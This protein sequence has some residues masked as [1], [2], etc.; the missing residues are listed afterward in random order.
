MNLGFLPKLPRPFLTLSL[1]CTGVGFL[2]QGLAQEPNRPQW[3]WG[4]WAEETNRPAGE[5]CYFRLP[6]EVQGE[7]AEANLHLSADNHFIVWL[8]G[9]R[10]GGGDNWAK[11]QSFDGRS[12]VRQGDNWLAV[13]AW[14]EDAAAGP[15]GMVAIGNLVFQDGRRLFW[16]SGAQWTTATEGRSGWRLGQDDGTWKPAKVWGPLGMQPWGNIARSQPQRVETLP[17]FVAEKVASGLG[18]LIALGLDGEGRPLVSVESGGLLRLF[19]RDG[20][21]LF[22][23]AESL[24]E[25]LR[26][27]QGLC[28]HEG[29]LYAVG[30]G[31]AGAALYR[32]EDS[33]EWAAVVR[34]EGGGEHG[35]HAVIPGPDGRLYVALGNHV[36]LSDKPAPSS[37]F[38]IHYEGHL[39]PRMLDPRGHARHVQTPGGMILA[40]EPE[41]GQFQLWAAGLRNAY[42]LAFNHWGDL[43]CFDADM[44]WDIGLPWYRPV[45]LYHV[46]PGADFGWRTGSSK[47]PEVWPD[48]L[49]AVLDVGRG[50]PTGLLHYQGTQ[51]PA[52]F[53]GALL[54]CDWAQG[55]IFAFHL[56]PYGVSYYG[57]NEVL[58]RGQPLNV[59]DLVE[60]ADGSLLFTTGGRGTQGALYRLR[61]QSESAETTKEWP[62]GPKPWPLFLRGDMVSDPRQVL[63]GLQSPDRFVRYASARWLEQK[64]ASSWE[65]EA[66]SQPIFHSR[67]EAL[68]VLARQ[69]LQVTDPAGWVRHVEAVS[70]LL[71]EDLQGEARVVALRALQLLLLDDDRE[72][73]LQSEPL[74][75]R[76]LEMF[77]CGERYADRLLAELLTFLRP[78]GAMEALLLELEYNP[79]REEQIHLA[80]CLR[81]FKDGWTSDHKLM[82]LT[83]LSEAALWP[84]GFSFHGYLRNIQDAFEDLLDPKEKAAL[85]ANLEKGAKARARRAARPGGEA[86]DFE[87]TLS[88]LQ[89]ALREPRRSLEEGRRVYDAL[90]SA[91]HQV[92][93]F[94]RGIGPELTTVAGRFAL[95]DLLEAVLRPSRAIS[96]Q[97]QSWD[98]W[99]H[100]GQVYTGMPLFEDEESITLLLG[101]QREVQVALDQIKERQISRVSLMPEGLLDDSTKEEIADLFAYLLAQPESRPI[102]H[103]ERSIWQPLF[104]GK[105]L[106]GWRGDPELWKVENGTLIGASAGLPASSFLISQREYGDFLLEFDVK[107]LSGNSGLQFRAQRL[108][109][110]VLHGYQADVGQNYWGSLYEEGGRGMLFHAPDVLW[111]P[112]LAVD[113]W[114]HYLIEAVGDRLRIEFNGVTTTDLR[115][116]K[117]A[118]G[119]LGFQL[120]ARDTNQLFLRNIRIQEF[121]GE[122]EEIPDY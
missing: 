95:P 33:G 18:S 37:P 111:R 103:P 46:I 5:R 45:R 93:D 3:I 107:L 70:T 30:Q 78:E 59:T 86:P 48:T 115:D 34:F 32:R 1:L 65:E 52:R 67:A 75:E 63:R 74:G 118:R 62:V 80:S 31:P 29:R 102:S 36:T 96:D 25:Q 51:F 105:S 119:F 41:D 20:N 122:T 15:A 11:A 98:L 112:A 121:V 66:L 4:A 94:G 53:R 43:F 6:F 21:G 58:V 47:W 8:N 28:W 114:N 108:D 19:D 17:G 61:Y 97:Y 10:L 120:H 92:G 14:N 60:E 9:V 23:D 55:M 2:P 87:R 106:Q 76:L 57:K 91:C 71:E 117:A 88:F 116:A 68:T 12:A 13:E 79:F 90:C 26:Y 50:S 64:E 104:D 89:Q 83:W 77:P 109:D 84:G 56:K 24:G 49:P 99:T 42:D 7:V 22:E 44:E 110:Y 73:R 38:H 113:G 27:V 54:G 40:V 72:G 82:I 81:H 69:D 101:D 39:L 100:R 16:N 85:A 35:P